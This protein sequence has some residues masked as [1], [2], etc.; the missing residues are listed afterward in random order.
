MVYKKRIYCGVVV[1]EVGDR[2][3]LKCYDYKTDAGIDGQPG[4][5]TQ[6]TN[7]NDVY[8]ELDNGDGI[9]LAT[10]WQLDH[11]RDNFSES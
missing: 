7:Q 10:C 11:I 9:L 1:F 2:V 8:V 4:I 6:A 5:V 3:R